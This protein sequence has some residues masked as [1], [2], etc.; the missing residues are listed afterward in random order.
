MRNVNLSQVPASDLG[1]RE[2]VATEAKVD[3]QDC[4]QCGKCTA[5]C[6]MAHAMDLMPRE[7]IRL[8]QL[9][10]I[11]EVLRAK[12]P[13]ICAQCAVCSARCPQNVDIAAIMK[14]VRHASKDAGY[15]PVRESDLFDQLFIDGVRNRGRSNEQYLAAKYNLASGHLLQDMA[16]APKMMERGMVGMETHNV[17][18]REAVRALVDKVMESGSSIDAETFQVI[19]ARSRLGAQ[20]VEEIRADLLDRAG[21]A[22]ITRRTEAVNQALPDPPGRAAQWASNAAAS[23]R[24]TPQIV[25]SG[26]ETNF[27]SVAAALSKDKAVR[28]TVAGAVG[29]TILGIAAKRIIKRM[30]RRSQ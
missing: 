3:F 16:N 11:D 12:T 27:S 30:G 19:G 13:W 1:A 21:D 9:G 7:L 29:G 28:K 10:L 14:A 25:Q 15:K 8:L 23:L 5:G 26:L 22:A 17:E 24:T 6:P 18:N 2:V 20:R 4:Y